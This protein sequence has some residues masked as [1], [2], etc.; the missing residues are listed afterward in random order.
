VVKAE[1]VG[2]IMGEVETASKQKKAV[3]DK[4][5]IA[6]DRNTNSDKPEALRSAQ[7]NEIVLMTAQD[8]TVKAVRQLAD[9]E[10]N[11]YV[12]NNKLL[13]RYTLDQLRDVTKKLCPQ[14]LK[15]KI[16]NHCL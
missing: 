4:G 14:T 1:V 2:E 12:W 16:S 15:G 13:F 11:G 3:G 6:R 9:K 10:Q 7:R 5:D 8:E